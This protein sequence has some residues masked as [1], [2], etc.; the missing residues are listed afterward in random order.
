MIKNSNIIFS[1]LPRNF[2]YNTLI[3]KNG[4]L[5]NL[6]YRLFTSDLEL[7]FYLDLNILREKYLL[8]YIDKFLYT[9]CQGHNVEFLIIIK[10]IICLQIDDTFYSLLQASYTRFNDEESKLFILGISYLKHFYNVEIADHKT[11]SLSFNDLPPLKKLMLKNFLRMLASLNKGIYPSISEISAWNY[12]DYKWQQLLI[13]EV[14]YIRA[15][16]SRIISNDIALIE[17]IYGMSFEKT[18]ITLDNKALFSIDSMKIGGA[19][20]QFKWLYTLSTEA[21][22]TVDVATNL[23]SFRDNPINSLTLRTCHINDKLKF[24]RL[25]KHHDL[26]KRI[27]NSV[28]T[29]LSITP[30]Y[31]V[32]SMH[33]CCF[34]N[35][36]ATQILGLPLKHYVR[37]GNELPHLA[38][39]AH[40]HL[41]KYDMIQRIYELNKDRLTI[42][43]NCHYLAQEYRNFLPNLRIVT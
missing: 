29:L 10:H 37:I 13:E 7:Y 14:K 9:N 43:V 28:I 12:I 23:I 15:V 21:L 39:Q 34:G 18:N 40:L 5:C 41:A 11:L 25:F 22:Q 35:L 36:I 6:S 24:I 32:S 33:Y 17:F 2:F 42:I 26:K 38:H 31:V 4:I 1:L 19:E 16:T 20:K 30:K 8:P 3:T 27:Y